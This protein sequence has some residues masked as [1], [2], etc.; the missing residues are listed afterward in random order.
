MTFLQALQR[1]GISFRVHGVNSDK[2]SFNCPF[3]QDTK[4]RLCVSLKLGWSRCLHCDWSRRYGVKAI[5]HELNISEE[6]SGSEPTVEKQIFIPRLPEDFQRLTKTSD[7]L[8][9]NARR[10]LLKRGI[11]AL[12]IREKR[13]GV[14]FTGKFRYRIIF[15]IYEGKQLRGINA[16]DFTDTQKPKYLN[17]KGDKYLFNFNPEAETVILSEGVIKALRIEQVTEFC[18]ASLL[19]HDLTE[20]QLL[21]LQKSKCKHVIIYPDPDSVG[22]RGAVKVAD[23]LLERW[24]GKV[25][26]V[27]PVTEPADDIQLDKLRSL[28]DNSLIRFTGLSRPK[29]QS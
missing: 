1:R 23:S 20:S 2:V 19:G 6:V 25:S 27:H 12:Q 5:L 7:E 18:S 8:D 28:L 10:Y 9:R 15:P 4:K 11:T 29:L 3:C 13:I 22:K 26:F 17:S 16:R 24:S 14:T 21:Q